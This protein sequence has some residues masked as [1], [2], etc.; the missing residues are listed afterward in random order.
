MRRGRTRGISPAARAAVVLMG[1]VAVSM[2]LLHSETRASG[3]ANTWYKTDTHVHSTTSS[4]AYEDL[5]LVAQQATTLGYNAIFL[6]DHAA[7]STWALGLGNTA[8]H[9]A[10]DDALNGYWTTTRFGST[11]ATSGSL[12]GSP[13]YS[14]TSSLHIAASSNTYGESIAWGNR[15]AN[16]RSGDI[17]LHFSVYPTRIDA[18]SG[19][20]VSISIG[21]DPTIRTSPYGYTTQAGVAAPG[22]STV[23][24]WQ[25]G[26][27]RAAS[28]NPNARI[29]TYPLPFTMNAW[30][31]YTLNV[32]TAMQDIPLADRPLDYAAITDIKMTAA[33]NHGT[34]DG[35]FDAYS[36]DTATTITPADEFVFRNS[37]VH[38]FDTSSFT[39]YT[40]AE[41]GTFRQSQRFNF[42][43]NQPSDWLTF[44]S[45]NTA[46]LP[47]QQTGYPAQLNCPGSCTP[48]ADVLNTQGEG[49]DFIETRLPAFQT[50][51]DGVL[52]QGVQI[53]GT[54][55]SDAHAGIAAGM[56]ATYIYAPTTGFDN[57]LHSL[58]EGRTYDAL[59]NFTGPVIFNLDPASQEPYPVRYPVYVP[60][61]QSTANVH[62]SIGSGL[63]AGDKI[64]WNVNGAVVFTD[65]ASGPSY[66]VTRAITLTGTRTYVRAEAR[67]SAG[68]QKALT[69]AVFF[70]ALPGLPAGMDLNVDH[71]NNA[72]GRL[73][74]KISTK[75]L[76]AAS[77]SG[78]NQ[79]LSATLTNPAQA[80]VN[81]RMLA[82]A[83]PS[84]FRVDGN[85]IQP[86]ATLTDFLAA[87]TSSWYY[88]AGAGLLYLQA[89]HNTGTAQLLVDFSGTP[90]PSPTPTLPVTPSNTSTNTAVVPTN[91]PG[92]PTNTPTAT[93]TPTTTNTPTITPTATNTNT[94][95]PTNTPTNTN[96]VA[97]TNTPTNTSTPTLTPTPPPGGIVVFDDGFETGD[98]SQWSQTVGLVVQ[99]QNVY[100]GLYAARGT[101]SGT[102]VYALKQLSQTRP[103]LY[104]RIR[105]NLLSQGSNW[106]YLERFRTSGGTPLLGVYVTQSTVGK[107]GY[108]NDITGI[109]TT[110]NVT[111]TRGAWHELQVHVLIDMVTG[112]DITETW[113]D[114]VRVDA[115]SLTQAMGTTPLGKMQLGDTGTGYTRDV[116]FDDV[117]VSTGFVSGNA[118]ATATTTPTAIPTNTNTATNTPANT[119]TS[120][121]A[122]ATNTN[123]ST[124]T[125]TN[126]PTSAPA[127]ATNTPTA[128]PTGL[129]TDTPTSTPTPALTSTSTNTPTNTST[130]A[131]TNTATNT[132]PPTATPTS[133]NTFTST[134]TDTATT[135]P[136]N[137]ST[138]TF[139]NTPTITPTATNT[140]V[141]PT[142]TNTPT[143][144]LTP[145]A[146]N[147]PAAAILFY[148]GLEAGNFSAW[149]GTA[150]GSTTGSKAEVIGAAAYTGSFGAH[151]SNGVGGK[152]SSGSYAYANFTA[153]ASHILSAQMRIEVVSAT[154]TGS[155]R[156]LQLR[157]QVRSKTAVRVEYNNGVWQ[158]VL[159]RRDGTTATANL[160]TGL[161][162]GSWQLLEATYDWSGAQPAATV[163]LNGVVQ[164]T[165]T[166][167][168]PGQNYVLNSVYCMAYEDTITARGDIYFDEIR[169]ANAYIGP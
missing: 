56:V 132:P 88:D 89:L 39:V 65:T 8:Y 117:T 157:D 152:A 168:T 113:F 5:G 106:A 131:P 139:T 76:T 166:D 75:G 29:I 114:G 141:P 17:I 54:W 6:T 48:A 143:N 47:T 15:A 90:L 73:Y 70:L 59:N 128:T 51:W 79:T 155:F 133:T 12:A 112:Q 158:L 142:A 125:P 2:L 53:I 165:I 123:T 61:T 16:F 127:T 52:Q 130:V 78:A 49:A 161:A 121:P 30:N 148:D 110:S 18:G 38:N 118:T 7:G 154:G 107:L 138:S 129:P 162:T 84:A 22:K 103:E 122:T 134:P 68:A 9:V 60:D 4:S 81:L 160:A 50:L 83:S 119:P 82:P 111:V 124:A 23:L 14:G 42:S 71:I 58:Y 150:L 101:S 95:A 21:G 156:V 43:I 153:P 3:P 151:F 62:L 126:T 116:V 92:S 136:S 19:L 144:T 159:L 10:F 94:A 28:S 87:T 69:Q 20:D 63:V 140:P 36:L 105:F 11:T 13:V 164:A 99:Q 145:T 57:L 109:S 74:T 35:Y 66:D 149:T 146:T 27:T 98:L 77:W 97:P 86:A 45:G 167:T 26:T 25:L 31:S 93:N 1:L 120:V 64:L 169:A 72:N 85:V 32:T 67:S 108:R 115:L 80:L 100:T 147:T 135:I 41:L 102:A 37:I 163:S 40:S 33:G 55:S 44:A 104:Y 24:I 34:A 46:I 96:T 91:T 137:T